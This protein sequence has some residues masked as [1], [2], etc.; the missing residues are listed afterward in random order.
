MYSLLGTFSLHASRRTVP[1]RRTV[2]RRTAPRT[3][4]LGARAWAALLLAAT[5]LMQPA[6]A[7][8]ARAAGRVPRAVVTHAAPEPSAQ[9]AETVIV[10]GPKRYDGTGF[11][12][13]AVEQITLPPDA[14]APFTVEVQNGAADGTGRALV[15]TLRLNGTLIFSSTELN[16]Q[17]P[18]QTQTVTLSASNTLELSFLSRRA[19]FLVVT[20]KA[21]RR[22]APLP[23]PSINDFN[24][25]RGNTGTAV[26]IVGS[27]LRTDAD[28]TI[29]TFAGRDGARV[30][31][32]TSLV[33]ASQVN[34][35]VPN[36]AVT[37]TIE[38]TTAGGRAVT[39]G[40]F[41]VEAPQD[42]QLTVA[43]AS[44]SAV[45]RSTATQVVT[46]TSAQGD[47]TQL[48][49]LA[50]KGLPGGLA[51]T[52]DPP[53]VT[54]GATST[55]SLSLSNA[56]LAPGSYAFN[57]TGTAVV[58][59]REV[60]RSVPATLNVVAAGQTTLAGRVLSTEDEPIMGATV[61][62][63]GRSTTTD[64]AG[65]FILS[66]IT[67][68]T[69]R[70]LMIDGRT[71]SAPNRTYPVITEPAR[72]VGGQA[73]VIPYTFYLPP[74][75]VQFEADV[76]PGAQT[77]VTTPRVEDLKMTIP[78]GANLRNRDG[79]PVTR[80][81]ITPLQIDRT[82]T[83][84]P[85]NVTAAMVY[86]S[87]PGGALTDIA[88]PVVYPNLTGADPG[89]RMS[90]YAF[91]HDTV[92]W[93]VYGFGRVSDDGR[94]IAPETDPSTGRPYGLRDFSWHFPAPPTGPCAGEN[95]NTNDPD[96]CFG[97]GNRSAYP[98]DLSS[99]VKIEDATDISFGGARG[100]LT[101][102]RTHTSDL[103]AQNINGMFGRGTVG[104]YEYRL[105]GNCRVGGTC[106]VLSPG[107]QE[108][109]LFAPILF[110]ARGPV[111][112][113][114]SA[115]AADAVQVWEPATGVVSKL[116][117]QL[118]L[119]SDNSFVYRTKS[120]DEMHFDASRRLV[121]TSDR[122]GNATTL[123]YTGSLLTRVTDPVGRSITLDYN[124]TRVS[125]ATDPAGR[126]WQ[127]A[128]DALN[129]LVGVTDPLGNVTRYGYSNVGRVTSVTDPR[130]QVVKQV[131]YNDAGRV[132]EER[133]ADGGFERFQY[134]LSG[135]VVTLTTITDALGRTDTKQLNSDG[136]VIKHVD[137][138]GQVSRINRDINT[139]L[140]ISTEGSCSCTEAAREFDARGNLTSITDRLGR[141]ARFEYDPA[142]N[143]T[144]K[145]TDKLGRVTTLA[146]DGRGNLV[147]STDALNQTTAYAYDGFGQLTSVTDPLGHVRRFEYDAGGN[148]TAATDAL[149]DR[150]TFEYDVL[151]RLTATVDALGRR[152]AIGYNALDRP[153]RVTDAAGQTT[154]F[155]Y[156]PNENLDSM[157]DALGQR[158]SYEY[159]ARNRPATVTDPLGRASR[160]E[161]D[162]DGELTAA[163]SPSGRVVRYTY[164]PRG[165]V[166]SS[167]NLL[168]EVVR[169]TYD[170]VGNLST[171]VDQRGNTTTFSYDELFRLV[172]ALNPLGQRTSYKYD[173]AGNVIET[174]DRLGR[175]T[176]FG[177]DQ[178]NRPSRVTYADATVTRAF[179]AAG[180][181][182]RVDDT[183]GGGPVVWA[184]DDADRPLSETTA[185]GTV[186]YAY[187]AAG[188]RT[189]MAA[190]GRA[191]VAYAYDDA[192]RLQTITRGTDVFTYAYDALSRRSVLQ[193]PNGVRTTYAYNAVSRLERLTH[194]NALNQ[195]IEDYRYTY[196]G[197][198]EIEAVASLA[199]AT[200]LP[201]TAAVGGADAAN[202]VRQFGRTLLS[203]DDEG[204]TTAKADGANNATSFTWD[205]RGRMTGARLPDGQA[206]GYS[207]DALGRMT[208]RTSG[209]ATTGFLYDGDA[210]V[211]D[212]AAG[213]GATDYLNGPGIDDKLLQSSA[214]TGPLYFLQD[215]LGSTTAL[216][217]ANG[218]VVERQQYGAFG[219][220]TGSAL[221]RFGY[222]GREHDHATGLMFYR[223]RW[224]DPH[225]GRFVT[226]D[227]I[228]FRGGI[229]LYAYVGGNPLNGIDPFGLLTFSLG[230]SLHIGFGPINIHVGGGIV[231][232]T[233][234]HVGL[235]T[236]K[237]CG[238][239]FGGD[240]SG[241]VSFGFSNADSITDLN[242]PFLAGGGE[243]GFGPDVSGEGF[244][245]PSPHGPV[246][247]GGATFGPGVGGGAWAGVTT[248]H[249][250]PLF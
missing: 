63:D 183:Q 114:T 154:R 224:Y 141:T 69:A 142:F 241:G 29:V 92:Q 213:G 231:V 164:D 3:S 170:N 88:I 135:T 47:F 35:L 173:A 139:N 220:S 48:A 109:R 90:L 130:G 177:Y 206:V 188:Q 10:F 27:A 13:K 103:G 99:G 117:D 84:L 19:A 28:P 178:L 157:T 203:F 77:V 101:L 212:R 55:L 23:S 40:V 49:H 98:V 41:T 147:S 195:T 124:G 66:G 54:A 162:A 217:A 31:A 227:P 44:V 244:T 11:L 126:T 85:S 74:I 248:T 78:A 185:G 194:A 61:S 80:A 222:T 97:G 160:M 131:T 39:G 128:Y 73:N 129:L 2:S 104:N 4:P 186:G 180:R 118:M 46:L 87:Q 156:D 247:G 211:L 168:G 127:Y 228:R 199:S 143:R 56:D 158:W 119:L 235:Y 216:T 9:T 14:F 57:V 232:D 210:A 193:R 144:T 208:S 165:Q 181:L 53:Q 51:A 20:V 94:T 25:K 125:R 146:Y 111:S 138:L 202:R 107:E 219:E 233:S 30:Q 100:R 37:G 192:G 91:N 83:P 218:G 59:G 26:T 21:T 184:Y 68:G 137:A 121:S 191:P 64:A 221:T 198:D 190:A 167:T 42:F 152:K 207:Y 238:A 65:S 106:R 240:V 159:D 201:A 189:S 187:N 58:D 50:A 243:A 70:P 123:E 149:G 116:G 171:L 175:L 112:S 151:S 15:G 229:N 45:Q 134:V 6:V 24:P 79:S 133:F 204:Q 16:L 153:V 237:G 122:N 38:L 32:L 200:T 82:P 115:A 225:Q 60:A 226:E 196:N 236:E 75:D 132:T 245:G 239:N 205:A 89:T 179:D 34:A 249:V 172:S 174:T 108:G 176:N 215:H 242:G 76:V 150:A 246:I 214:S 81:S 197:D 62:L 182:T 120:G 223:A 105:S 67:E 72:V 250:T 140:P 161:Y 86:T 5:I 22:P 36:G 52:F 18:S 93:Y 145:V 169:Y 155:H 110:S 230:I 8:D 17:A 71:A 209:G 148:M 234:G 43:P 113:S 7:P 102:S 12:T 96:P 33:T 136:Y 1:H 95:C 163:T 166:L